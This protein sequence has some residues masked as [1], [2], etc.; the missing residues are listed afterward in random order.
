MLLS[1]HL[2]IVAHMLTVPKHCGPAASLRHFWQCWACS[3]GLCNTKLD[4]IALLRGLSIH[5]DYH[6]FKMS[7]SKVLSRTPIKIPNC[8][9]IS[10]SVWGCSQTFCALFVHMWVIQF[11]LVAGFTA[12]S[13]THA[14]PSFL[15]GQPL[16]KLVCEVCYCD[17]SGWILCF[18]FTNCPTYFRVFP[19]YW[20]RGFVCTLFWYLGA[21]S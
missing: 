6:V 10:N 20:I 3:V 16:H 5:L 1:I 8:S 18:F 17:L 15:L 14:I 2:P 12:M 13:P 19:E 7:M 9:S 11:S 21:L 4:F